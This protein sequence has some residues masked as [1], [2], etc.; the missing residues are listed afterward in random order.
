[1]PQGFL[2]IA[3]LEHVQHTPH[4]GSL[5]LAIQRA[6]PG[7]DRQTRHPATPDGWRVWPP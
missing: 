1:M 2:Q 6:Q 7:I 3:I 5:T 4:I